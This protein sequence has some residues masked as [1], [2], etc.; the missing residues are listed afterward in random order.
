MGSIR[1]ACGFVVLV[2]AC[3]QHAVPPPGPAPVIVQAKPTPEVAAPTSPHVPGVD[4]A[5]LVDAAVDDARDAVLAERPLRR[6]ARAAPMMRWDGRTPPR[7]LNLVVERLGMSA[8]QR[9]LLAKNGFVTVG[10]PF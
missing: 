6:D 10:A 3:K 7:Y 8:R 2:G 5:A 9:E 4:A 1:R